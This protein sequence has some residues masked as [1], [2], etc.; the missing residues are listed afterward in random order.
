[1]IRARAVSW[2]ERHAW[3][4]VGDGSFQAWR[5]R[6][7]VFFSEEKKQKTF[8]PWRVRSPG[9]FRQSPKVLWFFFLKKNNPPFIPPRCA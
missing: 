7:K 2:A 5:K 8:G 1:M 9:P 3:D 4:E 6:R